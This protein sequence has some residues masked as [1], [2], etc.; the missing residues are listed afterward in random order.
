MHTSAHQHR[1]RMR[2]RLTTALIATASTVA[3]LPGAASADSTVNLSFSEWW[4]PQMAGNN[5]LQNLVN[6][7]E[8]QNPGIHV[9]L[10]TNPYPTVES[11]TIAQAATGTMADVVGL[12]GSWVNPLVKE[13]A[14]LNLSS[15]MKQ[16]GFNQST[17]KSQVQLNGNTYDIPLVNFAYP[18]FTNTALLAKAGIAHPPTDWAQFISDAVALSKLSKTTWGWIIPLTL[19]PPNGAQND[20]MSWVWASGGSMLKKGQPHL[21]DNPT[22]LAVVN[23]LKEVYKD[24]AMFP[25][26]DSVVETDKV[27]NFINGRIGMMIDSM[28]DSSAIATG[29][30]SLK[31]QVSALP[32]EDGY[33]GK[34]GITVASWGI[35]VSAKSAHPLQAWKFVEF[36][37]SKSVNAQIATDASGF[38]GNAQASPDFTGANPH[39]KAAF[40]V[41]QSRVP[42]NEFVGLP[43]STQLM[44]DFVTQF[45]KFFAGQISATSMLQT[46]QGQWTK[47]F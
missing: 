9:T 38:P 30:P 31:Y 24:G 7:F 36:L 6:Q 17:L 42:M 25:G 2:R 33:K 43:Q 29:A 34:Q 5:S 23:M 22:V 35:G 44:T 21:T 32:V 40:D 41:Y 19:N 13:G 45:Q 14:L 37:C 4:A 20:V 47:V 1:Q 15:E 27:E 39:Y 10:D 28:A 46:V 12:D 16:T 8:Q 18:L 3:F 26:P 11:Q